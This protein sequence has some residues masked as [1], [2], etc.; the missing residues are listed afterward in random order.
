MTSD[1]ATALGLLR[2]GERETVVTETDGVPTLINQF[3]GTRQREGHSLHEVSYRACFKPELPRFFVERFSAPF[4]VVYDPFMGRGTTPIEALLCG[5][6]PFGN[7]VNPIARVF[8][9]PRLAPPRLSAVVDRLKTV[10]RDGAEPAPED[11]LVFFHPDTLREIAALRD[12]LL[13]RERDGTLDAVDRWIRMVAANRL[14]GH[15]DGFFSGYTM[16]PN[17]AVTIGG[18]KRINERLGRTPPYRRIDERIV[19]KSKQL[20]ADVGMFEPSAELRKRAQLST[21]DAADTPGIA[22]E[23]VA[24]IVTS[25]PFLDVIAYRHDHWLRSWFCGIDLSTVKI[26][27]A[28]NLASWRLQMTDVFRELHRVLRPGGHIAFE[29]GEIRNQGRRDGGMRLEETVLP[30]GRD[31]GLEPVAVLIHDAT[32]TKT[33]ICWGIEN[34]RGG[35]NTNRVVLFRKPSG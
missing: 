24:L 31:A 35:T 14:T 34:N 17:Q 15:S 3:W 13:R 32:F 11:L 26:P 33:A 28:R 5:R 6:V 21:G 23:A 18:Q 12:H 27:L 22:D 29:V 7:D 2:I 8:C 9:E 1:T 4:D 20:L 30:C 16:P 10:P 19:R 25:P